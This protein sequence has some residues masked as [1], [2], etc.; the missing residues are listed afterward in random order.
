[1]REEPSNLFNS[2]PGGRPPIRSDIARG[3]SAAVDF[4][5]SRD[6]PDVLGFDDLASDPEATYR[7]VR[8]RLDQRVALLDHQLFPLPKADGKST[9]GLTILNPYDEMA[10]RT[11]VGRCSAAIIAGTDSDHVLNGLIRRPGPGWFSADFVAQHRHRRHLQHAHYNDECTK[12][13]GFFDVKDFFRQCTHSTAED[14]LHTAGAPA[15]AVRVLTGL[16]GGLFEGGIGLP[17]GFEGSGPI[18]NLFLAHIDRELATRGLQFVRWT[19]DLDVF[20]TDLAQWDPLYDTVVRMLDDVG[21]QVNDEKTGMIEKSPEAEHRLLDPGRDSVFAE[22]G[23]DD[24]EGRLQL[25]IAMQDLGFPDQVPASH[26]RSWLGALRVRKDPA[27]LEYLQANPHWLDREPRTVGNYLAAV[28]SDPH[29]RKAIDVDWL[30]DRAV[31]RVPNA[32]TSAGQLH[33]CRAL[34]TYRVDKPEAERLHDFAWE[35]TRTKDLT[36]GAWAVRAWSASRGWG[37]KAAA[38]IVHTIDHLGYRRAAIVGFDSMPPAAA[39]RHL[40]PIQR[41]HPETRPVVALVTGG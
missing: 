22:D 33:A 1:M 4:A 20:L 32:R 14:L 19:D 41:Q 5:R 15:G 30:M 9:R 39:R 38:H 34:T 8:A 36:V 25:E 12:G 18:A 17:I 11:Y 31:G 24:I 28:A 27:A 21:L 29:A 6:V 26:L 10:L 16:L 40:D 7:L 37:P 2:D 3:I 23:T 35:R 13:V